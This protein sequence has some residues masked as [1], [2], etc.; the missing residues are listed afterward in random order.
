MYI[1]I[2]HIAFGMC[3][4]REGERLWRTPHVMM[5]LMYIQAA[6]H[7]LLILHN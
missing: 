5:S 2:L 7:I 3:E 6:Q 1:H 4:Y